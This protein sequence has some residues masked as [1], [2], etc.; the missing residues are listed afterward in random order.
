MIEDRQMVPLTTRLTKSL[1]QAVK[2]YAYANDM[3]PSDV[4]RE[5]IWRLITNGAQGDF[6]YGFIR[7]YQQ[8]NAYNDYLKSEQRGIEEFQKKMEDIEDD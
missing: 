8:F 5:A 7:M 4:V 3:L 1:L 2:G 6:A